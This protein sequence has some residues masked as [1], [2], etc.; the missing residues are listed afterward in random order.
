MSRDDTVAIVEGPAVGHYKVYHFGGDMPESFE[1]RRKVCLGASGKMWSFEMDNEPLYE[2][3]LKD[4]LIQ[5]NKIGA[6]NG[7]RFIPL[8]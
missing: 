2:G 6:E 7:V 5:A 1:T 8:Q 4:A 3:D